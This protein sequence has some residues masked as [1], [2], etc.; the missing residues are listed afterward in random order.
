[1]HANLYAVI[2]LQDKNVPSHGKAGGAE[3]SFLAQSKVCIKTE[4]QCLR[5]LPEII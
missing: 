5:P 1:M 2:I 3:A 4:C